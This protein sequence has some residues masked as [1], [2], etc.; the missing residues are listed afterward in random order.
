M[1]GELS[2]PRA[3]KDL[4]PGAGVWLGDAPP[5]LSFRLAE[6]KERAAPGGRKKR[7]LVV[8]SLLGIAVRAGS[9]TL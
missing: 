2:W 7:A 9:L 3:A 4:A 1:Q 5:I 6:K 8:Y